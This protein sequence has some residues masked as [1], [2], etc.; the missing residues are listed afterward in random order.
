[1]AK[2]EIVSAERRHQLRCEQLKSD[3]E[4]IRALE[5]QAPRRYYS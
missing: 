4:A 3:K 1:M 5:V 2:P